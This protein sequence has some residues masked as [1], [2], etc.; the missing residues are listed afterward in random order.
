M[1]GAQALAALRT[2]AGDPAAF[3]RQCRSLM[4][5]HAST[6][7]RLPVLDAFYAAILNRLAPVHSVL[8]LGCGLNPLA[9]PW[10]PLAGDCIYHAY[11]AHADLIQF[12]TAALP[13]T[14]IEGS[15][16]LVDLTQDIPDQTADLALVLKC[17]PSLEQ[18][19]RAA[20]ARLL[21]TLRV[22]HMVVSFPVWSLGGRQKGMRATYAAHFQQIVAGQSWRVEELE[23]PTELVYVVTTSLAQVW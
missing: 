4:E 12:L 21:T 13:L 6:R 2:A 23:F 17:L 5:C 19:D 10:M 1:D 20:G 22:K 7:E 14:G 3:R 8:D 16:H 15:A 11:D 9:I 18:L